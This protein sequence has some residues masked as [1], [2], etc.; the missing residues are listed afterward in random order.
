MSIR[1]W[2]SAYLREKFGADPD[3]PLLEASGGI[4]LENVRDFAATGTDRISVGATIHSAT[5]MDVALDIFS[6]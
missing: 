3:R 5:V 1:V 6:A 2:A 4:T